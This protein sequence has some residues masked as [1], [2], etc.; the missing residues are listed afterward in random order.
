MRERERESEKERERE[1]EEERER[2]LGPEHQD[3]RLAKRGAETR[4][5]FHSTYMPALVAAS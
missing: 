1:G 5:V 2:V 3:Q 4:G